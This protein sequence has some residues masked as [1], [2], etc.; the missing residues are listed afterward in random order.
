MT[1]NNTGP[2]GQK[3]VKF[4]EEVSHD[5]RRK[6][7]NRGGNRRYNQGRRNMDRKDQSNLKAASRHLKATFTTSPENGT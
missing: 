7:V 2:G 3:T 1:E 5:T 4:K 6:F